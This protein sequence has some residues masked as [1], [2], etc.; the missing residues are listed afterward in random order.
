MRRHMRVILAGLVVLPLWAGCGGGGGSSSTLNL[1]ITDGTIDSA[2]KAVIQFTGV[3][4]QPSGGGSSITFNFSTPKLLDL[5]TLQN[6]NAATLLNGATVAAG[7]TT[8]SGCC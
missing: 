5:L 4:V 8:G 1:G 2:N 3:E 7:S 6:G